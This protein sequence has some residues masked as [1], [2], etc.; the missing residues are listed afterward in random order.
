MNFD[1][2]TNFGSPN[3]SCQSQN[4]EELV[5]NAKFYDPAYTHY[6]NNSRMNIVCDKCRKTNLRY[7]MGHLNKDLC[8]T[9]YDTIRVGITHS[10]NYNPTTSSSQVTTRM[11]KSDQQINN[12]VGNI[13]H[14]SN[15]Y[16]NNDT[17]P[18][19]YMAV[20]NLNKNITY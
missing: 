19:T 4:Y 15:L 9:C 17:K 6:G 20:S 16:R 3:A 1:P 8:L 2:E 11:K 12:N 14:I 13:T 10:I 18:T 7:A 5:F